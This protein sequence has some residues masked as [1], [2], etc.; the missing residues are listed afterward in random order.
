MLNFTKI[1]FLMENHIISD[2]GY[3][4]FFTQDPETLQN[5]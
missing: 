4:M 3:T 1:G 5:D 2:N